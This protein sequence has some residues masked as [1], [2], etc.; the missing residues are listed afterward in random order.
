MNTK[1]GDTKVVNRTDGYRDRGH[2]DRWRQEQIVTRTGGYKP[3]WS[4]GQADTRTGGP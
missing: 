2:K 1:T 4:Q 3:K